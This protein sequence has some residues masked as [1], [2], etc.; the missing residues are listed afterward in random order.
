MTIA[1]IANPI[2]QTEGITS[3]APGSRI[4]CYWD[5]LQNLQPM[6]DEGRLERGITVTVNYQDILGGS[7]SHD[8]EIDPLLYQG[9]RTTGYRD[10][11]DLV[12]IVERISYE[13]IGKNKEENSG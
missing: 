9:L 4:V 11:S 6:F 1:Q 13:G 3:L 5:E 10:V 7:Y 12:D 2:I 8:W